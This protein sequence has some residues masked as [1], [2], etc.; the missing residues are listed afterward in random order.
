MSD[1][2]EVLGIRLDYLNVDQEMERLADFM[3]NDK[4][5]SIGMITMNTLLLAEKEPDWKRYLENLDMSVISEKEILEAV[6]IVSGQ[7][8]EEVSENEFPARMFWYLINRNLRVFLLGETR[9]EVEALEKYLLETY[10]GICIVG[11]A[12]DAADG[13]ASA[14]STINEI[15]SFS[16]DVIVSGLQ[17][18]RQDRFLME[19]RQKINGKVWLGLGEHPD[20]QN[21][22]GLK[23]SW[24]STLLKKTT[25]RRM[26]AKFKGEKSE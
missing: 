9:E 17:G 15:N 12:A 2:I 3:E 19:N 20:I 1:K 24:W 4:L 18:I 5:D 6:D 21:E 14:D 10:P 23:V 8:Y 22:A 16:P 25:F 26:A 13:E 7:V 11:S